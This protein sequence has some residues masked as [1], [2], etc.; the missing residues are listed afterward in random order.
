MFVSQAG[1]SRTFTYDSLKRLVKAVNPESNTITYT[2]DQS[3]NLST[4]KDANSV[5]LCFGTWAS[6]AC[7]SSPTGYGYDGL[8]RPQQKTYSDGATAV[9]YTYDTGGA[10]ANANGELVTVTAGNNS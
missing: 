6:G 4:R 2:Y 1:Q 5:T 3:G 9:Q 10:A 7:D 8:N